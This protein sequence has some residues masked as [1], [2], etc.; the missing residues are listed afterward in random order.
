MEKI[1]NLIDNITPSENIKMIPGWDSFDKPM[2]GKISNIAPIILASLFI[3]KTI[4]CFSSC[5]S[6]GSKWVC[7]QLSYSPV[8]IIF[9]LIFGIVVLFTAGVRTN[10]DLHTDYNTA[11]DKTK[12]EVLSGTTIVLA[13]AIVID[14]IMCGGHFVSMGSNF[15]KVCN[16]FHNGNSGFIFGFIFIII[17]IAV[18]WL[19]V[20]RMNFDEIFGY[21]NLDEPVPIGI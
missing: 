5:S 19:T 13:A 11:L 15:D 16:W 9:F 1:D 14:C 17:A 2:F 3:L 7:E 10:Y 18:I 21:K 8:R 12:S 20:E 4:V 6:S